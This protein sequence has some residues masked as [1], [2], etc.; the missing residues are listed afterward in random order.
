MR[1]SFA[2]IGAAFVALA[3][4]ALPAQATDELETVVMT[5]EIV[6]TP[7]N[8]P[9]NTPECD[10][11]ARDT[12]TRT[13]TLTKGAATEEGRSTWSVL[14]EADG[15]FVAESG[16]TGTLTGFVKYT[17]DGKLLHPTE[18]A[19]L[20]G[21]SFDYSEIECKRQRTEEANPGDWA[22]QFFQEGGLSATPI[23]AWS[24]TYDTGCET[25]TEKEGV[26]AVGPNTFSF[27]VEPVAPTLMAATCDSLAHLTVPEVD[28][29]VYSHESGP[30]G[31]GVHT[32]TAEPADGFLFT[33]GADA[34]WEF[35]VDPVP[36]CPGE[37][38]EPG[39]Q[40]PPGEPGEPGPEGPQG[41][42]G[43]AGESG[44]DVNAGDDVAADSNTEGGDELP[45]TGTN[46]T[47]PLIGGALAVLGASA[48]ALRRLFGR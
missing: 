15:T 13:T 35:V 39:P 44:G 37:P 1:K 30:L 21:Q 23:A 34:S 28:G 16:I 18:L 14:M 3:L 40:G 42:Q 32:V 48:I 33:K 8:D 2:T 36:G 10:A 11:W 29:V 45:D 25:Y 43:P 41:P 31:S 46:S 22:L 6:A 38:G 9:P 47:L 26:D 4:A 20:K 5:N 12:F 27:C 19:K 24:Y 7:D 17:V